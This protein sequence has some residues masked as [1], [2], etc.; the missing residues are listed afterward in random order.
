MTHHS[1]AVEQ[2][3][4]SWSLTTRALYRVNQSA[5]RW[6]NRSPP[7]LKALSTAGVIQAFVTVAG[8][9]MVGVEVVEA[10]PCPVNSLLR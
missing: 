7:G 8:R 3:R 6:K 1:A 2:T 4:V 9:K 10:A 5:S